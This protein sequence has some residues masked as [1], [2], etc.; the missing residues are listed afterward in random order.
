MTDKQFDPWEYVPTSYIKRDKDKI[1]E[2]HNRREEKEINKRYPK[3]EERV[4]AINAVKPLIDEWDIKPDELFICEW[5]DE[6]Y[7]IRDED[8]YGTDWSEKGLANSIRSHDAL[9]IGYKCKVCPDRGICC[10]FSNADRL[11]RNKKCDGVS[12]LLKSYLADDVRD[13]FLEVGRSNP[14]PVI[15]ETSS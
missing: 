14:E 5:G 9:D 13:Y 2:Y 10:K 8:P 7:T 11:W 1:L 15:I 12:Q 3:R 6:R 4:N